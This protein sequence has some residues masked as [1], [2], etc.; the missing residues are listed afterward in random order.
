[1]REERFIVKAASVRL[2]VLEFDGHVGGSIGYELR[3]RCA[4]DGRLTGSVCS[5]RTMALNYMVIMETRLAGITVLA[6]HVIPIFLT[7]SQCLAQA[8]V[9]SAG[10][11]GEEMSDRKN[12]G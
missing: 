4:I 3:V 12:V 10:L 11:I 8:A 7:T 9:H 1:M 2:M 5:R 6:A